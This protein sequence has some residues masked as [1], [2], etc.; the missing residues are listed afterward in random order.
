MK[1]IIEGLFD[2]PE[3]AIKSTEEIT[4]GI[5]AKHEPDIIVY[6]AQAYFLRLKEKYEKGAKTREELENNA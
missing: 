5:F 3:G 1:E 6:M 2:S 4:C